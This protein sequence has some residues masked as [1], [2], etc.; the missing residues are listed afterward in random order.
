MVDR[1][2]PAHLLLLLGPSALLG[3]AFA[4]QHIGGLHPCE[5]CIWQ[6][7]P[8]AIA[9]SLA[10][11]ALFVP[12]MGKRALLVLAALAEL[13]TAGIGVF[14]AGVE[15]RWWQGPTACSASDLGSGDFLSN[16]MATPV[17][18]CDQIAWSLAGISMAG[19]NA[20]FSGLIAGVALWLILKR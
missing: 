7:W 16:V 14:H 3:G 10:S 12:G 17:V 1:L 2:R 15:Q 20:I 5:M 13:V 19:Y 18:Q 4:F 11:L 8:H 6:R 9:L